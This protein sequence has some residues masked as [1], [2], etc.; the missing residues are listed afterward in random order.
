MQSQSYGN[1][2]LA[3]RHAQD[4][5]TII[6]DDVVQNERSAD[7][8]RLGIAIRSIRTSLITSP[9]LS[10]TRGHLLASALNDLLKQCTDE[11]APIRPH[12]KCAMELAARTD[13]APAEA[14]PASA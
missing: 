2:I 1:L 7:A 8:I 6:H 13:P 12:L 3:L 9:D 4:A 10:T 14:Q 5:T 11:L